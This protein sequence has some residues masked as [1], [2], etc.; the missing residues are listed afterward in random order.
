[1]VTLF[2]LGTPG[3]ASGLVVCFKWVGA[4]ST[5]QVIAFWSGLYATMILTVCSCQLRC[6]YL[7]TVQLMSTVLSFIHPS[8]TS[9]SSLRRRSWNQWMLE[10]L[11]SGPVPRSVNAMMCSIGLTCIA[12]LH[13]TK[14]GEV[15]SEFRTLGG[16]GKLEMS[17]LLW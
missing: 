1:M 3:N 2:A 14:V 8:T 16:P 4:C 15:F 10:M 12:A 11:L 17:L 13:S 5:C 7:C 9:P 6:I